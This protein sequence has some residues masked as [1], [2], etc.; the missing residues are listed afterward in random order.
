MALALF[1]G[2]IRMA[3]LSSRTLG[4]A[5]IAALAV[6][7]GLLSIANVRLASSQTVRLV[8]AY[9]DED[10]PAD[11]PQAPVWD[12]AG[13]VEIP[14]S[15]QTA[16]TPTGGGSIRAV[17]VRALNDGKRIYFRLEWDDATKDVSVFA[18][19]DF[20]DAAAIE[21]PARGVSS[22]PSFCMGQSGAQVDIWHWKADWQNDIDN[23]FV[24]VPDV[25]PNAVSDYYPFKDD[26]TFYPGRESGNSASETNRE[27]PVEDL[28][29]AGFGTL[30]TAGRQTV[31]G[32]GVWDDGRWYVVF[33]REMRSPGGLYVPFDDGSKLNVAFAVWDGAEGERDGIKSVSS[34]ADLRVEGE[35][36]G[37][38]VISL[39]MLG[40]LGMFGLAGFFYLLYQERWKKR[41]V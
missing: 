11:N 1:S 34:F 10:V 3:N 9:S 29:A 36:G 35:G 18:P 23:G 19:E 21:F 22:I 32:R 12:T 8:A 20:R 14:L 4:L 40:I 25:Y 2:V 30:T 24:S 38:N 39:V 37:A 16:T 26:D 7:A 28:V 13:P 17:T 33:G 41:G 31:Q 6:T 27:T 5:I 15:A